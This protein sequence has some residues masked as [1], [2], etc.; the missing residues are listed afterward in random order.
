MNK[1]TDNNKNNQNNPPF[2]QTKHGKMFGL[3]SGSITTLGIM[4]GLWKSHSDI[5]IIIAAIISVALSDSFSDGLGMYFSQRTE[6]E[7][8]DAII[9]GFQ[10]TIYKM[11]ITLSYV[12]PFLV[13]DVY[14]AIWVNVL[15][16]SCL[17]SYASYQIEENIIH[18]LMIAL[19]V[20]AISYFGGMLVHYLI[21]KANTQT[22][23]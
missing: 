23:S 18:N 3:I 8:K 2:R 9:I 6:K 15:W 22:L 1:N 5:W 19:C 10:T 12:I 16:A 20:V 17:I 13:T 4:T 21:P 11:V 14:T 7:K